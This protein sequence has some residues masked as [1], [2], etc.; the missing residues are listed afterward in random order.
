[1]PSG[2]KLKQPKKEPLVGPKKKPPRKIWVFKWTWTL[3]PLARAADIR[4]YKKSIM[5]YCLKKLLKFNIRNGTKYKPKPIWKIIKIGAVRKLTVQVLL[6]PV[7]PPVTGGGT[8]LPPPPPIQ[9]PPPS[10]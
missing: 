8:G 9:P 1:M 4:G 5:D 7:P 2:K 6:K 3:D 10:L